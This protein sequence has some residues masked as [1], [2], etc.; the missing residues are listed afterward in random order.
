MY[1]VMLCLN[2]FKA[3]LDL[4]R[5]SKNTIDTYVH[6]FKLFQQTFQYS[7]TN[8]ETL[9]QSDILNSVAKI[10]KTKNYAISSQKQLIGALS[11]FY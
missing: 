4:K 5:Y 11:L 1:E 2:K 3:F 8:L 10:I 6:F 9:Q 7:D